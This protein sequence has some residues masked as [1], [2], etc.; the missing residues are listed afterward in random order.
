MK[1]AVVGPTYPHRGGIAHYTS[2]LAA[3]LRREQ[4]VRL[5][6][7]R[8]LY[9]KWLFPGRSQIDPSSAPL[10]DIE[11]CRWLIPWWPI[12]WWRLVRDW[13]EW[14]PDM[15]VMQWWV[16]FMAPM[17]AWLT[18]HAHEMN[19]R[20]VLICH[21]VLPHERNR[22]D[23]VLVRSALRW[24]DRLIVH[25]QPDR[26]R[27]E[28]LLPDCKVEVVP[29]PSYA[30]FKTDMW[31]RDQARSTLDLDGKVL[32]FFGFV[33][34]YKGLRDLFAAL[35]EVLSEINVTLLVVGEIWGKSE[36]YHEQVKAL[37]LEPHVRF[38]D[39]YVSNDEA[40]MYF[41]ASDLVILPYRE[42]TG[43]AVLQL[44]FGLGVPVIA[45]RTGGMGEA[46][47]DGETG[48][49]VEPGDVA[50]LSRAIRRFFLENKAALFRQNIAQYQPD[51]GWKKLQR[52][53]VPPLEESNPPNRDAL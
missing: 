17:T 16:P 49:L 21:N 18:K 41:A 31:T 14:R 50:S 12:S 19:I 30:N 8:A 27:A 42:A 52:I 44:A 47:D 51:L 1:I 45:T 43:S 3:S 13:R 36:T 35:P 32:L 7:F 53:I 24:A 46:V 29:L 26:D 39:R 20:V 37:G 4:E 2:L 34:P 22:F 33:R 5:Y 40:V 6:G 9:P 15:I 11:A 48:F 25:S 28:A 38:I 10:V 23:A